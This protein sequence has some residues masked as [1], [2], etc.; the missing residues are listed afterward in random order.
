MGSDYNLLI[1]NWIPVHR[2]SGKE[3]RIAPWQITDQDDPVITIATPRPDFSGALMEFLV[4]LYQTTVPPQNHAAWVDWLEEPPNPKILQE[5][6]TPFS[7]VFILDGADACFMQDF[8]NFEGE[9]KPINALLIDSPGAKSLKDNTDHFIKRGEVDAICSACAATA[10]YTLQTYAPSGGVGHRTSL[11]GGGPL[12][13]LVVVDPQGSELAATL[14]RNIWLNV[15]DIPRFTGFYGKPD[16]VKQNHIFPWLATTRSSESKTGCDTTIEDINPLQMYWGMPR[17]I[18]INW[19]DTEAGHCDLCGSKTNTLITKYVT[20][21]YGINYTGVWQHPLSPHYIDAKTGE[22]MPVH[23]Q[24]GGLSY[25]HWLGWAM[26][27]ETVKSAKVVDAYREDTKRK[28]KNEQLRLSVFGYDM[29][30]MKARCWYETTFP[31]FPI[32]DEHLRKAFTLRVQ[33]LVKAATQ[34]AGFV[35]TCIKEAW[36]KRPGDARG[37]TMFLKEAFYQQTEQQFY[38]ALEQ[39][40]PALR[41]EEDSDVLKGWHMFLKTAAMKL[42]DYW[43]ARSDVAVSDPRRIANAHQKLKN[44]IYGKKFLASLGIDNRKEKAA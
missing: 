32:D 28:L 44:L 33:L 6:L 24:P 29:D 8:E 34:M 7:D 10:L 26:G 21:N 41:T 9:A 27:T 17:R 2:K 42:F 5:K 12:T 35:Q 39:L 40:L 25:R 18:R 16:K 37:D 13:T 15:L 36:F 23:A 4:G 31:L 43:A 11:R 30:N 22:P 14:W 3:E 20:R 1:N 38:K 19:Q